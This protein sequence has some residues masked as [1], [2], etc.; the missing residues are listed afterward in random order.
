MN[1]AAAEQKLRSQVLSHS[2]AVLRVSRTVIIVAQN[3]PAPNFRFLIRCLDKNE[4]RCRFH[5]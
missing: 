1:D 5:P 2:Q 3:K 4:D